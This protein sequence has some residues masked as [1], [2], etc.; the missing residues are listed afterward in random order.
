MNKLARVLSISFGGLLLLLIAAISF[1]IGWRP[2]FGPK[3]RALTSRKFEASPARLERGKYIAETSG[4]LGC[5]SP[6]DWKA[7]G[8]PYV[9]GQEGSGEI[10]PFDDLPG[11]IV[12]PNLTPD[13]ETGAGNWT[14]D[15][16]ARAIRE[17][18]GHDGR[19]L[20][21]M[22]PYQ[23]LRRMSDEDLASVIVYLRSLPPVR[24]QLPPTEIIFPVKYLIRS[25]PAPLTSPVPEPDHSDPVKWGAYLVNRTACEE[26]HTAQHQGTPV[27]GLRFAGG[28]PLNGPFGHVAAANITPDASGIGYYDEALFIQVMRTGYVKARPLN[29]IMPF[30]EFKNFTDDDLKAIFAYLRTLKPV[31]HRV[32]NSLPP[33][34][35]K[36][37][38][39]KHG[40]GDQN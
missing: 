12:A 14:D 40:A 30:R 31:K 33:T 35:C 6:H 39:F 3:A 36:L 18:I 17:G 21:P 8:A 13:P 2:F 34:Y 16:L 37:C 9:P 26:C 29:S 38:Q 23:R 28:F 32:D 22:M 19:A 4:C 27:K 15:E 20:F 7:W 24:H 1:T 11:R 5:H 25:A 10:M